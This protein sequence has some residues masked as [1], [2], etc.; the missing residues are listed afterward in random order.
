MLL[1]GDIG[2]TNTDLAIFSSEKG[3][4]SPLAPAPFR[5]ADYLG[6]EAI[7]H[8][9]LTKTDITVDQACF[10]VAG[11]IRDGR[12]RLTN[13]HWVVEQIALKKAMGIEAVYLLND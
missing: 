6:L 1:A 4:R 9:F 12:A 8:E 10:A 11:P 13:L 5:S 7:I 3:P 2:G